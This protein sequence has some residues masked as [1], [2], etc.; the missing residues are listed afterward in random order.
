[1]RERLSI[2]YL[3]LL[4]DNKTGTDGGRVRKFKN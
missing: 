1:M 4:V 2:E 3:Q